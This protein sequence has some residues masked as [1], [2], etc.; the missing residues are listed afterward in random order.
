MKNGKRIAALLGVVALL[1]I[2]CLPM[3]FA[4]KGDF[5]QEA[6][7]ASLYTVL[8]VAV[9]GYVIWMV[10]RLVNKKKNEEDKRMIKNIV[11]DVGLVLV[12]FNWQSYL[13][14]FHFDKEKRDKIAKA[15]FQ[16]EV[17]D[18]RDKGLLEERE[19]REKFKAL[20]PEYAE[21]I[22]DVIR[23]STRCVT[24]MDYAETWT[25]YLKEQGYNLYIL[26]NYSRYMLDGTKQN[27]MPF[28]KYMDGVIF[29]CDVNQMK[30]DIEIY[31]TL[32][33]KFNLKA[34]ETL[35]IDDRA[36][37][38]QGAEKAGIHTIQ[39]KDL[40]QAAKEMEETYGIK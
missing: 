1:I 24:K 21:D 17:W 37:N 20:A 35:F 15:T 3:F 27:E 5:S 2:F 31:Q 22:E 6:F 12:E 28:L 19:Y 16:S 10:F 13:D 26:S 33:S 29:S 14:S 30:P 32:L 9:M 39:F 38:C 23:N 34:E 7:M 40:K 8:F 11:F 25:K 36:E 18:E 4:L